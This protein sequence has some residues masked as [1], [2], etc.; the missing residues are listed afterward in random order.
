MP[1]DTSFSSK[2]L[3]K[4]DSTG[5]PCSIWLRQG[6]EKSTF[7]CSVCNVELLVEKEQKSIDERN[8]LQH[9]LDNASKMLDE[10][11]SCLEVAV[12]TKNFGDIEVAQLLIGGANKKLDGL[13]TQLN[14]NSE[15]MNQLRKKVKK[16]M[17]A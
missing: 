9:K 4:T 1:H 13:Q 3:Q 12:A 17:K 2:W 6:K 10:G 11:N 8:I 15:Q 7:M 16:L 5:K 14:D